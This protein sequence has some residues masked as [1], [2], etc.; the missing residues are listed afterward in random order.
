MMSLKSMPK[1]SSS[2][3]ALR[4]GPGATASSAAN[5]RLPA[6]PPP[7][8]PLP[9]RAAAAAPDARCC[10]FLGC[11]GADIVGAPRADLLRVLEASASPG[12]ASVLPASSAPNRPAV[13][14]R[15]PPSCAAD[16]CSTMPRACSAA[17]KSL[18]TWAALT[19][20]SS[21]VSSL[22][23]LSSRN[24][25]GRRCADVIV[26]LVNVSCAWPGRIR[27]SAHTIM[28]CSVEPFLATSFTS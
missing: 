16:A 12:G 23:K 4:T 21:H 18:S 9:L 28:F 7:P 26:C 24:A 1:F 15:T 20:S 8:P 25:V 11:W 6:A 27:S 10:C 3:P 19:C 13:T 5:S 14:R 17:F 22:G 2:S